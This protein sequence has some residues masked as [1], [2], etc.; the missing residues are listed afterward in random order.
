MPRIEHELLA[1]E[2]NGEKS[3]IIKNRVEN[4][5]Q[6]QR[7]RFANENIKTNS[8]MNLKNIKKYCQLD[9]KSEQL[10][11]SAAKKYNLSARG[12]HKI[13]KV[14]R[15]IADLANSQN[16]ENNHLLEALNCR[17]KTDE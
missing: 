7:K 14:A 17:L 6:I 3:E 8:E 16:I 13:L 2:N 10:L 9:S 5:R 11:L 4:A 15:T 1:R 12:Y